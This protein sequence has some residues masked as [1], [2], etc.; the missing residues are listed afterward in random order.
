VVCGFDSNILIIEGNK[1]KLI[2]LLILTFKVLFEWAT[3]ETFCN[4]ND[5]IFAF[6]DPSV[7]EVDNVLVV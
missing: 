1:N 4:E 7:D 6:I 5:F 3:A 2:F